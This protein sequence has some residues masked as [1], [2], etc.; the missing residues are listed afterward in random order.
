MDTALA[1]P[2]GQSLPWQCQ[3]QRPG[4]S[5]TGHLELHPAVVDQG[6]VDLAGGGV[7]A[8]DREH[9]WLLLPH[10]L[11]GAFP[12]GIPC[13]HI[14]RHWNYSQKNPEVFPF[15]RGKTEQCFCLSLNFLSFFF[16][17]SLN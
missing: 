11:V 3:P 16:S 10:V 17:L 8:G 15:F 9:G 4:V 6:G 12:Q 2:R 5:L 13:K 1:V 7:E 14:R